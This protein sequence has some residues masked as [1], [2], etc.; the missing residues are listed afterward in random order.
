M[1]TGD[2]HAVSIQY[3]CINEINICGI[4]FYLCQIFRNRII[5]MSNDIT[6]TL[7]K[8]SAILI[9]KNLTTKQ[10]RYLLL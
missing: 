4:T 3:S 6:L 2:A 10:Y 7:I 1:G 8:Q 9:I 5:K